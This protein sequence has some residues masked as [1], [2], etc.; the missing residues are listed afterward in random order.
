MRWSLRSGVAAGLAGF[1]LAAGLGGAAREAEAASLTLPLSFE[2][3]DGRTGDFGSVR[4]DEVSGGDLLFKITLGP[5]LG[6]DADLHEFYFNLDGVDADGLEISAFLCDGG[7][8]GTD[9]ELEADRPVRGGAGS[10]FDFA[11]NLGNG[12]GRRGNGVLSM[13]S[14]VLGGDASLAIGDL[15]AE[16]SFTAAGIETIFAAHVQGTS[17]SGNDDS[18]TVGAIPEPATAALFALGLAGLAF[19]SRRSRA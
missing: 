14:F 4:V 3:D 10:D 9:F 2:F 11:V 17:G 13:A 12:A 15:L 19:G 18:E 1:G 8:C 5:D 6:D 7:G 16:H